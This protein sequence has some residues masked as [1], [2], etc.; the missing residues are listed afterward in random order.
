MQKLTLFSTNVLGVA[1]SVVLTQNLAS[2]KTAPE[3][4][5]IATAVT[6]KIFTDD[7]DSSGSGVIAKREGNLYTIV[8]NAHVACIKEKKWNKVC[9]LH[10][11]YTIVTADN[12]KHQVYA[13]DVKKVPG[14]LDLAVIKIRSSKLYSIAQFANSSQVKNQDIIYAAGFPGNESK[15]KFES[16]RVIAN[17]SHRI[18]ADNGGYTMLYDAATLPGMSGSAL[19]D[20]Q[21][22]VVAIHGQGDLYKS[23]TDVNDSYRIGQKIGVNRG[24]P[25]NRLKLNSNTYISGNDDRQIKPSTAD[26]LLIASYNKSLEPHPENIIWSKRAA[27]ELAD[28]AIELR[29]N[30]LHAYILRGWI[31]SQLGDNKQALENYNRAVSINNEYSLSYVARGNVRFTLGDRKGALQDLNRAIQLNPNNTLALESRATISYI[32]ENKKQAANDLN[33]AVDIS[34]QD[35]SSLISRCRS[36]ADAGNINDA[37]KDCRKAIDLYGGDDSKLKEYPIHVAYNNLGG[38]EFNMGKGNKEEALKNLNIAIKMYRGD[39]GYYINRASVKYTMGDKQGALADFNSALNLNS[40]NI[41]MYLGIAMIQE[42][43]GNL[44]ESATFYNKSLDVYRGGNALQRGFFQSGGLFSQAYLRYKVLQLN[45]KPIDSPD[46][47]PKDFLEGMIEQGILDLMGK[48]R[49]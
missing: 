11:K 24:I 15:L 2:A 32:S 18:D 30:Y 10:P 12:Q 49:K 16:G 35:L 9:I 20:G 26:G 28:K 42:E 22:R 8:T 39:A 4:K 23:G 43:L 25:A 6:V 27:L 36:N 1:I 48:P 45:G 13:G 14:N 41:N 34:P 37:L 17:V 3:I 47:P 5:Q 29:P 7:P 19:F 21:G 38:A 31:Y 33:R 40:T 46:S 44:Q